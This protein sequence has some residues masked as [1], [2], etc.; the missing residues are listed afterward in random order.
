MVGGDGD[1]NG[2]GC[3]KRNID[4]ESKRERIVNLVIFIYSFAFYIVC[5]YMLGSVCVRVCVNLCES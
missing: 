5:K 4:R 1:G 2:C 3:G